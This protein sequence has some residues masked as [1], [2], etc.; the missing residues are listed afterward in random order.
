MSENQRL[1]TGDIVQIQGAKIRKTTKGWFHNHF[2]DQRIKTSLFNI[3]GLLSNHIPFA[4]GLVKKNFMV[5]T[6][7]TKNYPQP[8][9]LGE[10]IMINLIDNYKPG[11]LGSGYQ[12]EVGDKRILKKVGRVV[13]AKKL[14]INVAHHL[15]RTKCYIPDNKKLYNTNSLSTIEK[16]HES[17][18]NYL[19]MIG[20]PKH[21]QWA[22]LTAK[23]YYCQDCECPLWDT[24]TRL[25]DLDNIIKH[26]N[27]ISQEV[28]ARIVRH[29]RGNSK[30]GEVN[31]LPAAFICHNCL[32]VTYMYELEQRGRK[33]I[34]FMSMMHRRELHMSLMEAEITW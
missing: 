15:Y 29:H 26:K 4:N 14:P 19:T 20:M 8:G 24:S 30:V 32:F 22:F 2:T 16:I 1:H 18:R 33:S 6:K 21:V 9:G 12:I 10:V 23:G 7:T 11:I 34:K 17:R 28:A 3:Q 5:T 31:I 25:I 13:D 27:E